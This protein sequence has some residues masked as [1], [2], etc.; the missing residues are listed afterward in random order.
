MMIIWKCELQ[1]PHK[2]N[3]NLFSG[4]N[5]IWTYFL[6]WSNMPIYS[7]AYLNFFINHPSLWNTQYFR[8]LFMKSEL[9]QSKLD[10]NQMKIYA[11]IS[12]NFFAYRR[13]N[14]VSVSF[15]FLRTYMSSYGFWSFNRLQIKSL[16]HKMYFP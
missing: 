12:S 9:I 14:P 7:F 13:Q 16:F 8:I 10:K 15:Y 6:V 1:F 3:E 11:T 2:W 4:D 5:E